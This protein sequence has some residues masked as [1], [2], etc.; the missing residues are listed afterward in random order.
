MQPH[1]VI[2][3]WLGAIIGCLVFLSLAIYGVLLRRVCAN[4][5]KVS[6]REFGIP[7]LF[8]GG[9]FAGW[10]CIAIARGFNA[11]PHPVTNADEVRG[12]LLFVFIMIGIAGFLHW[13][14]ID[15]WR[16][17]GAN[18]VFPLLAPVLAAGFLFAAYPAIG[19]VGKLTELGLG[20]RAEQQEVV[21]FFLQ[22][23]HNS[24]RT[25]L[26]LTL[27]LGVVVAPVAEEFLFRGYLYGVM[28]R[29]CGPLVAM[30]L[31]SALFAAV[32]LNLA[33]LPA[34]FL[35]A[36]CFAIVYETTGCILVNMSMHALFNLFMF[37]VLLLV[38]RSA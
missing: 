23:L 5:G 18:Q 7:D 26:I 3:V 36:L 14:G 22:S 12:A 33:S 9:F 6:A 11:N 2:P 34:L 17:F 29:Y 8:L 13:R 24:N 20:A 28:K 30:L 35:L 21:K 32:H 25:S 31:S 37:M 19:L 15:V 4:G 16:Q 27:L 38:Q 1:P 10:F